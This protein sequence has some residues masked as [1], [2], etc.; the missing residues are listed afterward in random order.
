M[1]DVSFIYLKNTVTQEQQQLVEEL[2]NRGGFQPLEGAVKGVKLS[3]F[4]TLALAFALIVKRCII[5]LDTGLGKTLVATGIINCVNLGFNSY[6]KC[7]ERYRP[8]KDNDDKFKWIVVV[9]NSNLETTARKIQNGLY[10]LKVAYTSGQTDEILRNFFHGNGGDADVAVVS[11][12]GLCNKYMN[13][14]LY[15]NKDVYRG[16][17]VDESH[18]IGNGDSVTALTVSS[19][20]NYMEFAFMLTATP[21]RINPDQIVNQ[22]YMLDREMFSEVSLSTYKNQFKVKKQG[23]VVAF[24]NLDYL[25]NDL[26]YRYIGFTRKELGLKGEYKTIPIICEPLE[27]YE[28]I[29]KMDTF[30]VIKGDMEGPAI[31]ALESIVE[32]HTQQGHKGLI[33][34]NL[35]ANKLAVQDYL[36][37]RGYRVGILDGT[38]TPSQEAKNEVHQRFLDGDLDVLITNI[39]TGKDL[40]CEYIVFYELTFDFKQFIGRGERGLQGNDMYLYFIIVAGTSEVMYFYENVFQRG[41]LLESI[42]NKD[43]DELH[44]AYEQLKPYIAEYKSLHGI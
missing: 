2:N 16:M 1:H 31:E 29:P 5:S 34:I 35:T 37:E 44:A 3:W 39:T 7:G 30:K 33:Y 13:E 22:I 42:S 43:V 25:K 12:Q 27:E 15:E 17:I 32:E 4:Q 24:R 19:I 8:V 26:W 18:T 23:K 14:F 36:E 11:Y 20:M 41:L 9:E 6:I 10:G 21:L 40:P 28:D 38:I